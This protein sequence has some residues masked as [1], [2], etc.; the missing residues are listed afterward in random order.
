M[1]VDSTTSAFFLQR[2]PVEQFTIT[3]AKAGSGVVL[4]L[5]WKIRGIS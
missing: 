3:P 5:E 2:N 1:Q 4:K